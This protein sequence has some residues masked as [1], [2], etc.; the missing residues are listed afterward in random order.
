MTPER[1]QSLR[2]GLVLARAHVRRGHHDRTGHW[3]NGVR[4]VRRYRDAK[5]HN[6]MSRHA[7]RARGAFHVLREMSDGWQPK[8]ARAQAVTVLT[9]ILHWMS[10]R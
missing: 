6:C 1:I 2:E 3:K 4:W 5:V 7:L 10:E 9:H 8:W